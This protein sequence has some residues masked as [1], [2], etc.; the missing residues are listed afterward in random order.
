MTYR[1]IAVFSLLAVLQGCASQPPAPEIFSGPT[2]TIA[3]TAIQDGR[4]TGVF[5]SVDK[6]NGKAV[7]N[8]LQAS[9]SNSFGQGPLM[10]I[11]NSQRKVLAGRVQLDIFG[12]VAQGAPIFEIISS[13]RDK[14]H[15]VAG[16][17][18]VE[19]EADKRYRV[20]G[21]LD[22]LHKEVWLEEEGSGKIVGEKIIGAP[23][24]EAIKAA[25]AEALFTCCN[26]RY[27]DDAWISDASSA[28]Q[29]FVPAGAAIKVYEFGSNRAK[30][31]IEG[32]P[33]WLGLDYGRAQQSVQQF[34]S[35]LAVKEDP[36]LKLASYPAPTQRA[37]RAGKIMRGM[38]KEQVIMSLG[39][40]RTDTTVSLELATWRYSTVDDEVFLVR[41]AADGLVQEID[42]AD[43][44]KRLV[45]HTEQ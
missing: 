38:T 8:N 41:W 15:Y 27:G 6:I 34:V 29:P 26:L 7:R 24:A 5:F 25:A 4:A 30:A 22:E 23:S 39:Y 1:W 36:R 11:A 43:A 18:E 21:I 13:L 19:L 10:R 32:A 44:L 37:I 45:V 35:R 14:L 16:T 42:A 31:M 20:N 2:A 12:R 3:D 40:P 17:I 28:T 9:R 33:M